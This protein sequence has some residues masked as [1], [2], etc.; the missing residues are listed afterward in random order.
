MT[1]PEMTH[2]KLIYREASQLDIPK[3]MRLT[4]LAYREYKTVLTNQ[5][6][7]RM[8]A[9]LANES[10]YID[11]MSRATGFVCEVDDQLIGVIFLIPKG[12]PTTIFPPEW[13]YIRL[14]G[15]DPKYRGLGIARK[16]T[17][18]CIDLARTNGETAIALHTSEFMDTARAMYERLGF[19]QVKE[20]ESMFDKRYWLYKLSF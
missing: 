16:L 9:G 3:I 18:R 10:R 13:S 14:L 15:V 7:A 20:L 1:T 5:N 12:N 2:Q 11:L 8:K 6:W 17:E 19:R 4:Q